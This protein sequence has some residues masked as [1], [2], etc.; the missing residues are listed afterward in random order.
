MSVLSDV[1]RELEAGADV[2][3]VA[4]RLQISDDLAAAAIDHWVDAGRAVRPARTTALAGPGAT[5]AGQPCPGCAP[6]PLWRMAL[7]CHGCP[8][9]TRPIATP[10]PR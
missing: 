5:P 3:T 9:A 2:A 4:R 1:L 7:S 6:R 8:F 10:P